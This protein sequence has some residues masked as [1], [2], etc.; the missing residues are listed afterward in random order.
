MIITLKP[1][2]DG[3]V[4]PQPQAT[5]DA[6]SLFNSFLGSALSSIPE[7]FGFDPEAGAVQYRRD[8]PWL[9][10]G[11]Q[12]AGVAVP[13]TGWFK[14]AKG[15]GMVTKGADLA[16][17]LAGGRKAAPILSGMARAVATDAPFEI[18]R[19]VASTQTGDNT[20]K[21]ATDAVTN[22]ALAGAFGGVGG[23]I[24]AAGRKVPSVPE[25]AKDV[26]LNDPI[27]L[28]LRSLKA[29]KDAGTVTS[30]DGADYWIN[31]YSDLV[32][33]EDPNA[34][35][36]PNS[37]PV[38]F[39]GT[40]EG[41]GDSGRLNRIWRSTSSKGALQG[42]RFV[43]EDWQTD[44]AYT[45][46]L[47][48]S[49]L[50]GKEDAVQ[51]P[52]LITATGKGVD[53]AESAVT[54]A[55]TQVAP[56][57]WMQREANDG[58]Y[59]MARR[60]AQDVVKGK[61]TG[62]KWVLFK[63]DSPGRFAPLGDAWTGALQQVAKWSP[64]TSAP[65]G[66][67]INDALQNMIQKFPL[68]NYNDTVAKGQL[69]QF[70]AN[71]RQK[72][73]LDRMNGAAKYAAQNAYDFTKA[74]V[75]PAMFQFSASPRAAYIFN[76][77]RNVYQYAEATAKQ[78]MEGDPETGKSLFHTVLN[79]QSSTG[80]QNGLKAVNPLI[81][82]LTPEELGHVW[83]ARA[84]MWDPE[85]VH[86]G[87]ISG[88]ITP[89]AGDA[90][91]TLNAIDAQ[92]FADVMKTQDAFRM[93]VSKPQLGHMMISNTWRGSIRAPV[94]D[95]DGNL[96]I[97]ASGRNRAEALAQADEMIKGGKS[98]GF[99][100]QVGDTFHADPTT[101]LQQ[102]LQGARQGQVDLGSRQFQVANALRV[103]EQRAKM[104]PSSLQQN[105]GVGGYM[106]QYSPWTK[107]ELKD[108]VGAHVQGYQRY[109]ARM[110]VENVLA[111]DM[112]KLMSE[113][114]SMYQQIM[115]RMDD[116]S[117]VPS[118][119][120]QIQNRISDAS[121]LG[122]ILGKDS[123]SK[124]VAA[125]NGITHHLQLGLGNISFPIINA[126]QP[127]STTLPQLAFVLK[128]SPEDMMRAG[129]YSWNL[130]A[131][132]AGKPK[133][134]VG[135]F[136]M[137]KLLGKSFQEMGSPS[138]ELAA[139]MAQAA[140]EGQW[141][142]TFNQEVLGTNSNV[143]DK[144][145]NAIEGKDGVA[146]MM[147][148]WSNLLPNISERFSRVQSFALGHIVG[149]DMMNLQGDD[150]YKFAKR[151]TENSNFSYGTADRARV[152]TGPMG[153]LF[154]LYKNWQMHYMGWMLNYLGQG[155][156]QG[157]WAPL[158]YQTLGTAATGGIGSLAGFG[159]A[160]GLSKM[161]TDKDLMQHVYDN[162]GPA[163]SDHSKLSDAV[164]F[165]LP[166]FLG[167]SLQSQAAE[168][169]AN[170]VRDAAMLFSL[171]QY[172]RMQALGTAIGNGWDQFEATG[173]NPM[174][175]PLVRDNVMKAL[176]PRSLARAMQTTQDGFI[177]SLSTG[178]PTAKASVG[179]RVLY[180]LGLNPVDTEKQMIVS[181]KLWRDQDAMRNAVQ[182]YGKAMEAA[183]GDPE[184]MRAVMLRAMAD[185]VPLDSI[186]KSTKSR[187]AKSQ[188]D[189]LS[190]Q[191][192]RIKVKGY[193][194]VLGQ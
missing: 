50:M 94:L 123:A 102:L 143:G 158:L 172:N 60:V 155:V 114:P 42:Q 91:K 1:G 22:L 24:G 107:Q 43:P 148:Q 100:W 53:H 67:P 141:S 49:G 3:S 170:P 146:G 27:P 137:A 173:D 80:M 121:P 71:T 149:R 59:V 144:L 33:R 82:S 191:F 153:S 76:V 98:N 96:V 142:S 92:H 110:N 169:G 177:R 194:D 156:K 61:Q 182:A 56:D 4:T 134:G 128:A 105:T 29:A 40:L 66:T 165:G 68:Q 70:M 111:P 133:T 152:I 31:R 159:A 115:A 171:V 122:A 136:N 154:G 16:E 74:H 184:G 89:G 65:I 188:K 19:T 37:D 104:R 109:Q 15:I 17:A 101:E 69:G 138:N 129:Y 41:G 166:A 20:G 106:G 97:L 147:T 30:P 75:A 174:R 103:A 131:D 48:S 85:R 151:F 93:E 161:L 140:R 64:D 63:T 108:I 11:S 164:Y 176:A 145:R 2:P 77:A 9:G 183:E 8:N 190:R 25:I 12:I 175:S 178:T 7:T 127:L 23:A 21:V 189:M 44:G 34:S 57:T 90:I 51:F 28:Q 130:A 10:V 139:H 150:L 118:K 116:L 55:L 88:E 73:G 95:A 26:N 113:N 39:V 81:D 126:L 163:G 167:T 38:P 119:L 6:N 79:G 45:D 62:A 47:S 36:A 32:R 83:L 52:R 135:F 193:E 124:S 84:Q 187:Q 192:S 180:A 72:L 78:I 162:F 179:Q 13:Y 58:L 46:A 54:G 117:G 86:Q 120:S 125:L 87:V 35:S 112:L 157:N 18:G 14:A 168:P 185:G 132:A 181:D 186:I 99:Q 160:D 5:G